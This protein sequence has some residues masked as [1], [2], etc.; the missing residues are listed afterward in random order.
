MKKI[1]FIVPQYNES[2]K[3]IKN[4]LDS[5]AIQQSI[6]FNDIS[7]IIVND[8]SNT[9][10]DNKFLKSYPYE[11]KYI[12]QKHQGVSTARNT[13]LKKSTAE[14][15]MFCDADD[16]FCCVYGLFLLFDII[17]QY[18]E[19]IYVNPFTEETINVN[20]EKVFTIHSEEISPFIHGKIFRRK[21]LLDKNIEFPEYAPMCEDM[22]VSY[23]AQ[24]ITEKVR[25]L[26]VSIYLW[27]WRDDSTCRKDPLYIP[28]AYE[29]SVRIFSDLIEQF[30]MRGNFDEAI[31]YATNF[32]YDIYY[33]LN[34]SVFSRKDAKPYIEPIE[35]RAKFFYK[36]YKNTILRN[37]NPELK[38]NIIRNIKQSKIDEDIKNGFTIK[39]TFK[40]WINH[41]ENL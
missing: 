25:M 11:I 24:A 9:L 37:I 2:E 17:N 38:N 32:L 23:L 8:G 29:F 19:D 1:E 15:V 31:Y 4:L 36:K 5:I 26:P 33:T 28:K 39:F 7:M 3:I 10:L 21:F 16:M 30:C 27:K 40:E 34:L 14:Y 41:L 20:N 13:G 12:K 35:V 18:H 6:N 22:Y